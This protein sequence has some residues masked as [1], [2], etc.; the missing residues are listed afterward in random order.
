MNGPVALGHPGRSAWLVAARR[1]QARAL[2]L[3]ISP[4]PT[5]SVSRRAARPAWSHRAI[6]I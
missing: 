4:P 6:A 2:S 3:S 5:R 1:G